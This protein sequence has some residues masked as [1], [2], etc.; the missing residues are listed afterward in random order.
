MLTPL[1]FHSV[2]LRDFALIAQ[3]Y[4]CA[5]KGFR[6]YY[7]L[8]SRLRLLELVL[9]LTIQNLFTSSTLYTFFG[10]YKESDSDS[11]LVESF[12]ARSIV[13]AMTRISLLH[14]SL[15]PA[16][17]E[18]SRVY[19]QSEGGLAILRNATMEYT[20]GVSSLIVAPC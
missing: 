10:A 11:P 4:W 6:R 17:F 5:L 20:F 12:R 19:A 3:L 14:S 18:K 16:N 13:N 9:T 2:F 8:Q 7:V 15:G 1:L